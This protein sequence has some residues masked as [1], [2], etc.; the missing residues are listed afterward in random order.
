VAGF[1][2]FSWTTDTL[3]DALKALP[4][5]A[6]KAVRDTIKETT[7]RAVK[8]AKFRTPVDTG[9]AIEAWETKF[10]DG[11]LTG[12]VT[13]DAPYINVLEFGGYPVRKA[14]AGAEGFRRGNAILGGRPP[15]PRTQRA[16]GGDPEMR[17]NVSRQ[18]PHGMVRSTLIAIAPQ[19]EFD[20]NEALDK[21]LGG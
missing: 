20:L 5:N 4:A 6:R 17:S 8:I 19:F 7:K 1:F 18:A 13:N 21:A 14:T 11:G 9:R 16:P 12:V 10:E 2:D 3:T 15:G